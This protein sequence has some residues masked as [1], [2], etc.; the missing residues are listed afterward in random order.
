MSK[1]EKKT[2]SFNKNY[3]CKYGWLS[4]KVGKPAT[5]FRGIKL[6]FLVAPSVPS[7]RDP[8]GA[9]WPLWGISMYIDISMMSID[10][11]EMFLGLH[12]TVF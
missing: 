12:M 1:L 6:V 3:G 7:F 4:L 2:D 10:T 9:W 5:S 8:R 11:L